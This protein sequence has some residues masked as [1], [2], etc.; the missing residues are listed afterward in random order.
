MVEVIGGGKRPPEATKLSTTIWSLG[1]GQ[2]Q[3]FE[4]GKV[5]FKNI[6]F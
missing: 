1:G 6:N 2:W 5:R 3:S 4:A